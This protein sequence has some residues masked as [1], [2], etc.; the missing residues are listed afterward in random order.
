MD[1]VSLDILL[2]LHKFREISLFRKLT[3]TLEKRTKQ[4]K[5]NPFEVLMFEVSDLV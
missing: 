2:D 1:I 4:D 5:A 3:T